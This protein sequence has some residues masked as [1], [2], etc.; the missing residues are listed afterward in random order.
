MM[1]PDLTPTKD[2]NN[3]HLSFQKPDLQ[4]S[5]SFQRREDNDSRPSSGNSN[6]TNSVRKS[7]GQAVPAV[8]SPGFGSHL[9]AV[10][11]TSLISLIMMMFITL[12]VVIFIME[13]ESDMFSHLTQLPEMVIFKNDYYDPFR[14]KV[15]ES[16]KNATESLKTEETVP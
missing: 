16:I 12:L 5:P 8:K 13:I 1:R 6:H 4:G 14:E 11:R 3:R 10:V 15:F 2:D 7:N 9:M